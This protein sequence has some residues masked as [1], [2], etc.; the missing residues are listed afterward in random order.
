M[1][2][3]VQPGALRLLLMQL[4]GDR[5]AQRRFVTDF[6]GLWDTRS[7]RLAQALAA[8]NAG[9]ARVTLLSIR[10]SCGILGAF[11]LEAAATVMLA[12]LADG[13]VNGCRERLPQM[14]TVGERTCVWLNQFLKA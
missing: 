3:V 13:D 7:Q 8:R 14:I 6:I 1:N 10:S 2:D 11:R 4:G 5:D 9:E 12:L